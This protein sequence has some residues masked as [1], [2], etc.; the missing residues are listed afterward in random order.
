M[1][2]TKF[3]TA[4]A[5]F[6]VLLGGVSILAESD[7]D[8]TYP[9]SVQ[10]AEGAPMTYN[11]TSGDYTGDV[12]NTGSAGAEEGTVTITITTGLNKFVTYTESSVVRSVGADTTGKV[13]VEF[14]VS[15][16]ATQIFS[17]AVTDAVQTSMSGLVTTE[18]KITPTYTAAPAKTITWIVD[19]ITIGTCQTDAP[20]I[21]TSP[22]K[23]NYDFIGWSLDGETVIIYNGISGD[24]LLAESVRTA[25]ITTPA[26][27]LGAVSEDI[28][29]SAV[30]EPVLLTVTF[31]AGEATVG[32]AT[33]PYNTVIMAPQ[34]P[35]GY[36]AWDF[37]F[38]TPIT[39]DTTITAIEADPVAPVTAYNVTFEI[40]GKA[41]VTQKSDTLVIPD[42]TREGYSFQGWVVKGGSSEYVDPLTYE[43][44]G[45]IT[46][47]AVYKAV[48]VATHIITYMDGETVVG[49]AVIEDG[50]PIGEADAP[51]APEGKFWLIS[52][53]TAPV[54]ADTTIYSAQSVLTVTFMVG[55]KVFSA[56]TQEVPYGGTV[57]Q[58]E[59]ADF[60][61]PEGY[62]GWDFDFTTPIT[63]DTVVSAKAIPAPVEEPGF[64]ETP[65]GQCAAILAVFIVGVV[66]AFG[67][68]K[69]YIRIPEKLQ[70]KKAAPVE[71]PERKE[72]EQ[73]GQE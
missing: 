33:A 44:T 64:F 58:S 68:S 5:A 55:E 48:V 39:A 42:T 49:T 2:D 12:V 52:D 73:E 30:F 41:P 38:S 71:V 54:T 24:Y 53:E 11:E 34:L 22:S 21:P 28:T 37:D 60:V 18:V 27:Y 40:E 69:G 43:I 32:T 51:G 47:T 26:Q 6:I 46:F 70:R 4:V 1:I 20:T 62:D 10:G 16:T 13:V 63:E 45:D 36:K 56:Y 7:A 72:D 3:I 19:G 25:T 61:F 67:F 57:D 9:V 29:L 14:G 66:L 17:F 23:A 8:P 31:I 59:L 65:M 15:G 50:K 35:E